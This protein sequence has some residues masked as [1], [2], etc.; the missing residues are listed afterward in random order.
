MHGGVE[1]N[2]DV[3]TAFLYALSTLTAG[4]PPQNV[5]FQEL[6]HGPGGFRGRESEDIQIQQ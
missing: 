4:L 6:G 5:D 2:A 3:D 1:V